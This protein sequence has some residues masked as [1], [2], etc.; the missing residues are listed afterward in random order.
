MTNPLKLHRRLIYFVG[1]GGTAAVVNISVVLLLVSQFGMHPLV[2]NIFAFCVAFNISFLGHKH[3]TFSRLQNQKQ[4]K[5]PH[6]FLVASTA[7]LINEFLYFLFLHFTS[8]NYLIALVLVLGLV[9]VYSFLL[10]RFWACR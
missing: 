2:A 9:S 5:L 1:I 10:S 8:L 3:L 7:G 6:F 4:L